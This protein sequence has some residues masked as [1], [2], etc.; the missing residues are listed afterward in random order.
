MP[1][2]SADLPKL[3]GLVLD[4]K[5]LGETPTADFDKKLRPIL[6]AYEAWIKDRETDLKKP[7]MAQHKKSR[8]T[9]LERCRTALSRIESGLKLLAQDEQAAEAFRFANLAM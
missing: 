2:T 3:A 9:A 7:D 5:D 8:Q 4:M 6:V 1:P